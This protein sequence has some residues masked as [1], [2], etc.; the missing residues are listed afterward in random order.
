V[1]LAGLLVAAGLVLGAAPA[2]A[3][4]GYDECEGNQRDADRSVERIGAG[5]VAP[6]T[7]GLDAVAPSTTARGVEHVAAMDL[8]YEVEADG[9]VRVT[10]TI[11]YDFG[12][13]SRHGIYRDLVLVR[14]CSERYERRYPLS[15]LSVTSPTGAPAAVERIGLEDGTRLRIGDPD[16]TV[17]GR[18]TYV[19]AYTLG[20]VL[21]PF[22]DHVELYWNVVGLGWEVPVTNVRVA[23]ATPG[24]PV[25]AACYAG[26]FGSNATCD[27][28]EADEGE[29]RA[30]QRD[31]RPGSGMTVVVALDPGDVA[32]GPPVLDE[33]WS[34]ARAFTPSPLALA[35]TAGLSVFLLGGLAVLGFHVGR[36]RRAE[37]SSVDVAFARPGQEG[38]P[39]GLFEG[40]SHHVE[41]APPDGLRPAQVA[42]VA[43]EEVTDDDVAA[44]IV[45][46]AVRG[47]LRIEEL[48]GG[49]DH[50]LVQLD[51]GR[52]D[53]L[54][55]ERLLLDHLFTG[56]STVVLSSLSQSFATRLA[57]VVAAVYRDGEERHWFA[58]RPDK[59]RARWRAGGV[60]GLGVAGL[61]A[62]LLISRTHLALLAIPVV[63]TPLLV[64][65]LAGRMPRRTPHGTGVARRAQGFRHFI[66][67]SEAPRARWA[68]Q[69]S[70]FTDY[71]PYAM[72]FGCADRW[73]TT[74]AP[75]GAAAVGTSAF[76]V[77]AGPFDPL[78]LSSATRG[79]ARSAST[80]L[81]STPPSSSGS[82][83]FSGGSSGG[84]GG[85]GGGGSW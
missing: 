22:A 24:S 49:D 47:H 53:L 11:E 84:G 54:G 40:R 18:H 71:L 6:G 19:V 57:K 14:P 44:T 31:V 65:V 55:Y 7:P 61:L 33:Q 72:V 68:E 82:S 37:G 8:R 81:S 46:L 29:V 21:D 51:G 42:L 64:V 9:D 75:L 38:V 77:G 34:L 56:R 59:V 23:V 74:F 5:A 32:L 85:G 62:W 78:R 43:N 67:D 45:D 69:Q 52:G 80:T 13:R 3:D 30:G 15:Q 17:Q 25:R 20:S 79:F 58:G 4:P 70:I 10:E 1:G 60:V 48:D 39:V 26:R 35:G 16:R 27:G 41:F 76:Y 83:G 36:D 63:L 66:E 28:L 50:R 73:A 2:S 12:N